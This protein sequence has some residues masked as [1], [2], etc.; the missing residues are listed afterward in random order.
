MTEPAKR[1]L[2]VG[3]SHGIGFELVKMLLARGMEVTTVSRTTGR[4]ESEGLLSSEALQHHPCD[5]VKDDLTNIAFPDE[6]SGF[7]YCPGSI[8][9]GPLRTLK[10]DALREDFELNVVAAAKCFQAVLPSLKASKNG[11]A[12]FFSTV[13][14]DRGIAMHSSVAASKGAVQAMVKT[15]AAELAPT[16]R[17]NCIAP[18]LTDTPL[19]KQLLATDAKKQAMAAKYPLNRIGDPADIAA[20]ASFL[21]SDQSSWITGQTIGVDGGMSAIVP[22]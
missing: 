18:A 4:L 21:L 22:L 16:I 20:T 13:A 3:G 9:L 1:V 11:T 19:A 17:V 7:V 2:V 8:N 15:W 5:V 14:V 10:M 12:V 6:L